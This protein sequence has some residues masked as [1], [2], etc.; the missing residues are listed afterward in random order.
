MKSV[1]HCH[2]CISFYVTIQHT[3]DVSVHVYHF[4]FLANT[5]VTFPYMYIILCCYL[6]TLSSLLPPYQLLLLPFLGIFI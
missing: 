3:C 5:H 4:M 1:W 6:N 2:T